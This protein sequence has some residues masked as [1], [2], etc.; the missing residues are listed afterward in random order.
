MTLRFNIFGFEIAKIELDLGDDEPREVSPV[1]KTT[2][3]I[4]RWWVKK[5]VK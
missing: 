3:A 2:K 1:D 5:M 4:S